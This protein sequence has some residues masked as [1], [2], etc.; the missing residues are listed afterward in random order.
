[1]LGLIRTELRRALSCRTFLA[2][3]VLGIV[4]AV[5][6]AAWSAGDYWSVVDRVSQYS[7]GTHPSQFANGV[8]T[9]WMPMTVMQSVPNI[10]F[11][12]APLL[13]GLSYAWSWRADIDGGYAQQLMIRS[14]R[15]RV[16]WAKA[17]ATFV[18]GA[19]VVTAP[20]VINLLLLVCLVPAYMPDITTV[21]YTGIWE[22]VFLSEVFYT[23]PVL[24]IL[25]R[26]VLDALLGGLWATTVLA[27]SLLIR[28]RVAI[29]VLPYMAL[30]IIKYVSERIYVLAGVQLSSLTILDQLKARGDAFYY[31]GWA[32]LAGIVTMAAVSVVIPLVLRRGDAL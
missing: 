26:L 20:L 13:V 5:V 25:L 21:I 3:E 31:S 30:V 2:A 23:F 28:N 4:A 6:A 32:L 9:Y 18:A 24:Y 1:M 16:Y 17:L 7:Q 15:A 11:F 29:I 14:E 22:K 27:C 19:A 10:Y 8:F 12:V